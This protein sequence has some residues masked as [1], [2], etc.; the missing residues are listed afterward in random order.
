MWWID[1]IQFAAAGAAFVA[2][3]WFFTGGLTVG[4]DFAANIAGATVGGAISVGLALWTFD[5]QQK[6][7]A[8]AYAEQQRLAVESAARS[9]AAY[10]EQQRLD[11]ESAEHEAGKNRAETITRSQRYIRAI[12]D[13]VKKG[14][15]LTPSNGD[16]IIKAIEDSVR[17]TL[18]VLRYDFNLV[19]FDLRLAMEQAASEGQSMV[20]ELKT[21]FASM[22]KTNSVARME[23]ADESCDSTLTYLDSLMAEYRSIRNNKPEWEKT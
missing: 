11:A 8:A 3:L 13:A 9:A 7:S 12:Y 23:S 5:R 1:R 16:R 4:G 17:V 18:R 10:A 15:T 2:V 6:A 22:D 19:D 21:K 14:K 20:K